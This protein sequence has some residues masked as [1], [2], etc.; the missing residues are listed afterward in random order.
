M[1]F[2]PAPAP[3]VALKSALTSASVSFASRSKA[4]VGNS[5]S[6]S[7]ATIGTASEFFGLIDMAGFERFESE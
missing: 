5:F 2:Q 3:R 4:E 6:L 1:F 7:N